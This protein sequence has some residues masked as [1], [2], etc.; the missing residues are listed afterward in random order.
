MACRLAIRPGEGKEPI[1]PG[2]S[3]AEP[4]HR[5]E[6]VFGHMAETVPAS[7]LTAWIVLLER[8]EGVKGKPLSGGEEPPLTPSLRSKKRGSPSDQA[9]TPAGAPHDLMGPRAA[10]HPF[11]T[12]PSSRRA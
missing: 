4:R 11:L 12:R 1:H 8:N 2:C 7:A 3:A 6:N 5:P 10:T 9:L